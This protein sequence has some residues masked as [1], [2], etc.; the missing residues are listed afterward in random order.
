MEREKK[1]SSKLWEKEILKIILALCKP[2]EKNE[3]SPELIGSVKGRSSKAV[4]LE[5][6]SIWQKA[7]VAVPHQ[8]SSKPF[9]E[10]VALCSV[11]NVFMWENVFFL[12]CD[13]LGLILR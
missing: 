10:P 3:N 4:C 1:S 7:L 12:S 2:T 6:P 8:R 5:R 13:S 9:S 11:A